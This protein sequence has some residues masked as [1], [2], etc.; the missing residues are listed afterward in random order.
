MTD[1][2]RQE[3]MKFLQSCRGRDKAMPRT[4]LLHHLKLWEPNLSDRRL[5]DIYAE[6][7]VATCPEGLFI[8]RTVREVQDFKDY[9]AKA[10]G[11]IL[12]ARRCNVI[13]SFYPHLRPVAEAQ[14]DLF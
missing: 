11:P 12:A 8:P 14:G 1:F 5:R 2:L 7:P 9:I 6:L 10:H 3:T 13:Y 4:E